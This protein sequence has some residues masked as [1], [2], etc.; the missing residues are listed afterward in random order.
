MPRDFSG[1]FHWLAVR[2]AGVTVAAVLATTSAGVAAPL[3]VAL[4][5][6]VIGHSSP[7]RAMDY[8]DAGQTVR[9]GPHDAIVLTYLHSCIRETITGGT[10]TVGTDRSE[11]QGGQVTRTK[12][13]CDER[14]FVLTGGGIESQFAGRVFRGLKPEPAETLVGGPDDARLHR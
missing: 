7:V 12:I 6:N 8:L 9:L 10:V 11:V 1:L 13:D 5:E 2:P 14:A 4:V 3:Q